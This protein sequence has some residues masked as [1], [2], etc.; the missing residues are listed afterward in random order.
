MVS[1]V[2]L[3]VRRRFG[4]GPVIACNAHGD[5][6]PPGTGWSVDPYGAE[7]R[8]GRMFGRGVAVSKSDFAT[9]AFAL[10]ALEAAGVA[11][12]AHRRQRRAAF[13]L[14]RGG[15]RRDRAGAAAGERRQQA[16]LRALGGIRPRRHHRAQR[17]PAPGGRGARQVG[18]RRRACKGRR[19][20]RGGDGH[21][22]RSLCVAQDLC[23]GAFRRRA[24]SIRRRWSSA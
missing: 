7:I 2:N 24:A 4:A 5:V 22:H 20:A 3:I 17:L 21:P 10:L 13:H 23:V 16:R 18:P 15:R 14:R 19:R 1:C 9:Y 12:R 8:D 11:R 6:V